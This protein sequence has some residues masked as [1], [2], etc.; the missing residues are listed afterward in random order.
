MNRKVEGSALA[1]GPDGMSLL[2]ILGIAPAMDLSQLHTVAM[3]TSIHGEWTGV[4][5]TMKHLRNGANSIVAMNIPIQ[6]LDRCSKKS[7]MATIEDPIN[8]DSNVSQAVEAYFL[9]PHDRNDI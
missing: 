4:P 3:L 6:M 5:H 2:A 1:S 9:G 8:M 7:N